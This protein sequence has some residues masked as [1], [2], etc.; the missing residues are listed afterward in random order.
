MIAA[1]IERLG[2]FKHLSLIGEWQHALVNLVNDSVIINYE[3][4][5]R[6][7]QFFALL[8]LKYSLNADVLARKQLFKFF[9]V[10]VR[11]D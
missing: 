3:K 1:S 2:C 6:S 7:P 10:G 4:G 8:Y 5:R 9:D 11:D